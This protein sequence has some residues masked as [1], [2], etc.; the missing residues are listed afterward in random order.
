[1]TMMKYVMQSVA[2]SLL[3][4]Q[5]S[6]A[7]SLQ[8]HSS[9][10]KIR[11]SCIG[12]NHQKNLCNTAETPPQYCW[13]TTKRYARLS[14]LHVATSTSLSAGGRE[15]RLNGNNDD[16]PSSP[17]EAITEIKTAEEMLL[18][19][20]DSA[21]Q[22]R[23]GQVQQRQ[24]KAATR[25]DRIS[26]LEIKLKR[27]D[28][29]S[30]S[31]SESAGYMTVAEMSELKGLLKVR[32]SFEEQYDPLVFT[33]EHLE[34]K[35]MHN[36]AF[37]ALSNYC[38]KERNRIKGID[39]SER[40]NVFFLDGPDG[41]TASAL[42]DRGQ[43]NAAQCFVANRHET[44]CHSLTQSGGGLL[45]DS[46]VVYA[47]ASEA[48]T[49]AAPLSSEDLTGDKIGKEDGGIFSHIDFSAYYFDG[50][51][52][53]VPHIVGMLSAALLRQDFDASKPIAVGFSLLGGNKDVVG[54]EMA[55]SQ[56]LTIIARQR[57]MRVVHVLDDPTRYGISLDIKKI[58][59]ANAGTFTT[60]FLLT[61][62]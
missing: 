35:A 52:G 38:E 16:P 49:V 6:T 48:L 20:E 30:I 51:G 24:K 8:I 41:G 61:K 62:D 31:E 13:T 3:L 9:V 47:T 44:S 26:T 54:K 36:D 42:I 37:I 53:F 27:T 59:G 43:F 23:M 4:L 22:K 14:I 5:L 19:A 18:A 45:P 7:F 21:R 1:M 55:V 17:L 29:V 11:C 25:E 40:A 15:R 57:G 10:L 50:C 32:D 12:N 56:A 2:F 60:W 39:G 34:F 33:E 28:S 58:G 46:N